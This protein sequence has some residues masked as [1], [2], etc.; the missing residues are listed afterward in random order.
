MKKLVATLLLSFGV[1]FYSNSQTTVYS[2]DFDGAL[3]W[4]LNT[5]LGATEGATPNFWYISCEEAGMGDGACGDGCTGSASQT[6]HVGG[7]PLLGDLGALY[8][9]SGIAGGGFDTD[10]RAES[11]DIS[12]VGF[13]TLTLDFEMIGWGGNALDYCELFYSTDGGGTWTSLDPSLTSMCCGGIACTGLDQGLW[14]TNSYALPAACEG[15]ANLRISFVWK[16]T[17]GM[18]ATD[19]SFAVD[20]ITITSPDVAATPIAEFTL[21]VPSPI[22]AGDDITFT[23]VTTGGD[24]PYADWSWDFDGA[25]PGTATGAGP[26]VVNF[27]T[28]GSYDITLTVTDGSANVDDTVVTVV[29]NDC[30]V[31]TAEFSLSTPTTICSG[32]DITFTDLTTGGDAPYASWD[33]NFDGATP[34]TAT[35]AGPHVVN[36]PTAGSY[37]ITLTVTDG[38]ANV[39]DTTVTVTVVDCAG[40]T[41]SFTPD[42]LSICQGDCINMNDG[43]LGAITGWGW[44]FSDA[45]IAPAAGMDPGLICFPNSGPVD[46]TL[47]V[48]DGVLVDDTTITIDVRP[49][50]VI[51]I[52][53]TPNDTIC[54][55][56]QLILNGTGGATYTW[57]MGVIDGVPFFPPGTGTVTY[58]VIG[59]DALGCQGTAFINIF[60]AD[61]VPLVPGFEVADNQCLGNCI[62]LQDTSSGNIVSWSWDFGG[63]A[64]PNTSTE[65]NPTICLDSVD[66]F[67]I[68]L[69]VTDIL[70]TVSSTTNSITVFDSPTVT[71]T[72]DT[73]I[74]LG[75]QADLIALL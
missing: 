56:D 19:P 6:L 53:A 72:L 73:L 26:H 48:T 17:D 1:V 15:I 67:D 18:G 7:N 43:S 54:E 10:R 36:F 24:A 65:Q 37:D 32:D 70:G 58:T 35:G 25:T 2:E 64:T 14:Q 74:D 59:E 60:I 62:T 41:A 28:A 27:P 11:G 21:S 44:T 29:V 42:A 66:V 3:T 52:I 8:F 68:Q 63:A 49:T 61:C 50:P 57:D 40:I 69:T 55:G 47:T 5:D 16:N 71:A 4:T 23:D 20:N 45:A 46:V 9:E 33:W 38:S 75:G 12:T 51:D 22:C 34:G 31:P 30:S 39:D 13:T